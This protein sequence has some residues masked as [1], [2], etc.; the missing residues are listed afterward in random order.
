M[1]SE[2]RQ[3][4]S[5]IYCC[6]WWHTPVILA[7]RRLRQED[8]RLKAGLGYT[9]IPGLKKKSHIGLSSVI[10]YL[11]KHMQSSVLEPRGHKIKTKQKKKNTKS[12]K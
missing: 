2:R 4:K 5:H 1:L 6:A 7:L 10:Q 11:T 12:H 8:H 3:T 9:V